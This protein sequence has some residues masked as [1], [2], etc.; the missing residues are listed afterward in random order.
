MLAWVGLLISFALAGTIL[1]V[2]F[3]SHQ[4]DSILQ[5][6]QIRLG[7]VADSRAGDVTNW[8][9]SQLATLDNLARNPS[10]QVYADGLSAQVSAKGSEAVE[11]T[12]LRNLLTATAQQ[13]GFVGSHPNQPIPANVPSGGTSGIAVLDAAGKVLVATSGMPPMTPQM[14]D[15][16][17]RASRGQSSLPDIHMGPLGVPV[18]GFAVPVYGVQGDAGITPPAGFVVGVRELDNDLFRRLVQPGD[19]SATAETYLVRRKGDFIEYLTPLADGTLPMHRQL[20]VDTPDLADAF[21][22]ATPGG[23]AARRDYR[24][25]EVLLTSR[26]IGDTPLVLIH[27]IDRAEALGDSAA[28]LAAML[29][30]LILSVLAGVSLAL[31]V[32]RH[33]TSV[34]LARVVAR[35]SA[36]VEELKLTV[37]FLRIVTDAQ[38]TE[39]A[40]FD[41]GGCYTF[42]NRAAAA[43]AGSTQDGIV[44]KRMTDVL[45]PHKAQPFL[46]L[47]EKAL[48]KGRPVTATQ[49]MDDGSYRT[50]QSVH[51]P[52][53]P[54]GA[55]G[56]PGI[57]MVVQDVTDLLRERR[58][59]ESAL[60]T[61]V[62]TLISVLDSLVPYLAYHSARVSELAHGI[63]VEMGVD[64]DMV[65]AAELAGKLMNVGALLV[66][67]SILLKPGKLTDEE[68]E[69]IHRKVFETTEVLKDVDFD[70]PVV[71]TLAQSQEL[72]D[73]TG[74]PKGLKGDEIIQS[75]RI[76]AVARG[77]VSLTSPRAYREA[78]PPERACDIL[79]DQAD[80]QFDRSAV[81]ALSNYLFNRGGLEK[82]AMFINRAVAGDGALFH[83]EDQ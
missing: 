72:W 6:W 37:D 61:L 7:I 60:E 25:H 76:V 53:Q 71:E 43:E 81:A 68:L 11:G 18:I 23:F 13:S 9:D 75:A 69:L 77:F 51:I 5:Q 64:R 15:T 38:P 14:Q 42:A 22:V 40:T 31:A 21:A 83:R 17:D 3:V 45:G 48:F 1:A 4:R 65:R 12:Y 73:G 36:M 39:I 62:T 34:R 78:I 63:A 80:H 41:A 8:L 47:N 35:N 59:S 33:G 19:T 82:T 50:V 54:E 44:G 67:P 49:V 79:S 56:E 74:Y 55:E 20:T 16:I 66:P 32:W 24:G 2:S 52:L 10:L 46:D 57:L 26:R 70:V 29:A 27:K 28:R 30:G 58:R